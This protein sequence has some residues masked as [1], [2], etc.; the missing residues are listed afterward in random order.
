MNRTQKFMLNSVVTAIYQIVVMIVGFITP[1][2]MIKTYGSEV[3]GLVSSLSQFILYITLVE[4]GRNG[5][6]V[7]SLYKPLANRDNDKI[8]SIISATRKSYTQVGYVFSSCVLVLAL[9]YGLI[10]NSATLPFHMIF[11][12]TV[13]L[14]ASSCLDFFI[15]SGYKVIFTADQKTYI[16]SFANI[17]QTILRAVAIYLFAVLNADIVVLYAIALIPIIIKTVILLILGKKQYP[18]LNKQAKPDMGALDKRWD[19]IYQQI[20]GVIQSGAPIIL[21]TFLLPLEIV[22]VYSV[23][24]MVIGGIN[25]ILSIF[26]SGLPASFGEIIA[27]GDGEV[28]KKSTSDFEVAYNYL[29]TV[30]YGITMVMLL[31]FISVYADG[32]TD[33]NYM[34]PMLAVSIVLNGFLYNI[35]TPQSMLVISSGMYKETRW[36]VTIQG[37]LIVV[38]GAVLGYFFGMEGILI[39]SCI[40]NLY[41]IIDLI[42]FVPKNITHRKIMPTVLRMI[43]ACINVFIIVLPFLFIEIKVTGYFEWVIWAILV[44]I[45]ALI[46]STIIT[47]V[48]DMRA[49]I[50]LMKRVKNIFSRRK[51]NG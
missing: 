3:N 31:P 39:G 51:I 42:F 11:V 48:F 40:S 6:S 37:V 38:L 21:A 33:T 30:V 34:L 32:F 43:R 19:V 7:F 45:Y 2:I 49:C 46:V 10:K 17:I 9:V 27:Q 22:S 13:R 18:Y 50:S 20:L 26:I 5:A 41:R 35:K 47:F 1:S 12:L 24:N 14:G 44:G 4:A 16:L 8:S 15:L 36:Q 25:G 23:Y 29:I 28:L